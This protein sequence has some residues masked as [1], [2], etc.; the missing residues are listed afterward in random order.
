M[1]SLKEMQMLAEVEYSVE[2][3]RQDL[4]RLTD[5]FLHLEYRDFSIEEAFVKERELPKAIAD[6]H[7]VFF[8]DPD[9]QVSDIPEDLREESFG[10]VRGKHV[11]FAGRLIYPVMDI[12][13]N[14][15]G[16]CGW[17][18]FEKPKY[19]DSINHGYKAKQTTFY[20]MEKLPEYYTSGKPV[21]AV[22][23]IVCC[24][25]LRS[26]GLQS[27][28]LLGSSFTEFVGLMLKR[29]GQKLI[30][31]PDNDAFGKQL[32]EL[33]DSLAGE[34]FVKQAKY[35]LPKATV[36]QSKVAKDVDD[37]RK[38]ENHKYEQMFMKE[39]MQVAVCPYY[40]FQTIRVR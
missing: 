35:R 15:M 16:F 29:F 21:Y 40:N 7:K 5:Y 18:K 13:G 38:I 26:I 19:L 2:D 37:T 28:A 30:L 8:V 25:Y 11:V 9:V 6:E 24:L 31:I 10:F 22:E 14:V 34:H 20:G 27:I 17:D 1:L 36:I 33:D 12:H 23:G 32:D 3:T 4:N 39:L